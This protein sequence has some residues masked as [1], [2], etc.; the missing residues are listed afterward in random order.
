[1]SITAPGR[2]GSSE[3]LNTLKLRLQSLRGPYA[4]QLPAALAGIEACWAEIEA[5][6]GTRQL[7]PF[8]TA[9]HQLAGSAGSYGFPEV[10]RQ[11]LAID[12]LI[13][14]ARR[15]TRPLTAEDMAVIRKAVTQLA[16]VIDGIAADQSPAR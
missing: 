15:E 8:Y 5:T 4:A 7:E 14:R 16:T 6:N 3:R 10:S 11:S 13:G 2:A 1:M 9:I 12:T